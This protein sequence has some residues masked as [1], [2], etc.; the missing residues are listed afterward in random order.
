MALLRWQAI[1]ELHD[2]VD[3][4][5]DAGHALAVAVGRDLEG[6]EDPAGRV[7]DARQ[8]V[9]LATGAANSDFQTA[10]RHLV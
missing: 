2:A 10:N 9:R 3:Q 4:L 5:D 8:R 7:V 1:D 6:C